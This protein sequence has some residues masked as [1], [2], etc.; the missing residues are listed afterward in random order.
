MAAT[1]RPLKTAINLPTTTRVLYSGVPH[2]P[3]LN[4]TV[5][6][7]VGNSHDGQHQRSDHPQKWASSSYI[8]TT[9]GLVQKSFATGQSNS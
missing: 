5:R 9:A 1:L 3:L 6:A 4:L 7:P 8:S 2:V